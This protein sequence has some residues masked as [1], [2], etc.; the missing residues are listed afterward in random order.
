MATF[1]G[2]VRIG[3]VLIFVFVVG[4]GYLPTIKQ[5]VHMYWT[6]LMAETRA[7]E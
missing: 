7:I 5:S 6:A 1:R 3:S 2:Q 4:N